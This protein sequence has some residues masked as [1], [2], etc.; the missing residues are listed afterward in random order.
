MIMGTLEKP[1]LEAMT[2]R[3]VADPKPPGVRSRPVEMSKASGKVD[4]GRDIGPYRTILQCS[5][6]HRRF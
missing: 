5:L 2:R 3:I 6:D 4:Q 1:G